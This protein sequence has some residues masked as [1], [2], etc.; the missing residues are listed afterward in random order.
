MTDGGWVGGEAPLELVGSRDF[1]G[2]FAVLDAE[3][4]FDLSGAVVGLL[5]HALLGELDHAIALLGADPLVLDAAGAVVIGELVV[6][7][8]LVLRHCNWVEAE[9]SLLAAQVVNVGF[10]ISD[11]DLLTDVVI[12]GAL[13]LHVPAV[14]QSAGVQVLALL[15]AAGSRGHTGEVEGLKRIGQAKDGAV[16][17]RLAAS[18]CLSLLLEVRIDLGGIAT[19]DSA[20]AECAALSVLVLYSAGGTLYKSPRSRAGNLP[21]KGKMTA[22]KRIP[23]PLSRARLCGRES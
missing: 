17:A 23:P 3:L 10:R 1:E 11:Q 9:K 12:D 16:E 8:L 19:F 7:V 5:E 22:L 6:G 4:V 2:D 21:V 20:V 13:E 18:L 14:T 15:L